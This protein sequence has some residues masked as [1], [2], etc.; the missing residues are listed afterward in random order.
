MNITDSVTNEWLEV[1]EQD[2][3]KPEELR[4]SIFWRLA[5]THLPEGVNASD[6]RVIQAIET[7][8]KAN[9]KQ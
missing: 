5:L 1:F 4:K 3:D 9:E 6:P 7:I 2:K 8:K